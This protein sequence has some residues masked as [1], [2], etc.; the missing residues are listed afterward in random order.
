MIVRATVCDRC[1]LVVLSDGPSAIP[2]LNRR[3][4]ADVQASFCCNDQAE[5][6]RLTDTFCSC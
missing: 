6:R 1:A 3:G 5:W 2:H 4:D